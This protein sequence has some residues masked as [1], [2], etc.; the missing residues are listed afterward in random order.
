MWE[1]Y[2]EFWQI[3][4]DQMTKE[5]WAEHM[6]HAFDE[7]FGSADSMEQPPSSD[8]MFKFYE[9]FLWDSRPLDAEGV[10]GSILPSLR[11]MVTIAELPAWHDAHIW[12]GQIRDIQ[13]DDGRVELV[14]LLSGQAFLAPP[15]AD[16]L[17][18]GDIF[19]GRW[20]LQDDDTYLPT[21]SLMMIPDELYLF[22]QK[23]VETFWYTY[24]GTM[25]EYRRDYGR[26]FEQ[27]LRD[28]VGEAWTLNT[29]LF[30]VYDYRGTLRHLRRTD[31][32]VPQ[33][34]TVVP[35]FGPISFRWALD[36]DLLVVL[37]EEE[38]LV[39]A[40]PGT[41][42]TAAKLVLSYTLDG[43]ADL[44]EENEH[45][46]EGHEKHL[47]SEAFAW[48]RQQDRQVA[49]L[50]LQNMASYRRSQVESALRLWHDFTVQEEPRFRKA[51]VWAAAVELA[52]RQIDADQPK[53]HHLEEKYGVPA[54]TFTHRYRLLKR[55]LGL[56]MG[57][58]RYSSL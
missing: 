18:L 51:E 19:L 36:S 13:R 4:L 3:A 20:L 6:A 24:D 56:V 29:L 31:G 16:S 22:L 25:E 8:E 42:L 27:W 38:L 21:P 37:D 45:W 34:C 17:E 1:S 23:R 48:P 28:L 52:V 32:I 39:A 2:H 57:D 46:P 7:Y 55:S 53:K 47:D 50:L 14:E 5:R 30:Q 49:K 58:H 15:W 44:V 10:F 33:E 9:W 26:C 54:A 40:P 12:I 11:S 43:N 41:D 35:L